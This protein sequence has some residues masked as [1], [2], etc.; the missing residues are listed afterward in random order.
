MYLYI[1]SFTKINKQQNKFPIN[2][3]INIPTAPILINAI[4]NTFN[5]IVINE[6]IKLPTVYSIVFFN[7]LEICKNKLLN[8]VIVKISKIHTLY[9]NLLTGIKKI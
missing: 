4:H 7:P 9:C 6:H 2:V 8:V 3:D 5:I 1:L